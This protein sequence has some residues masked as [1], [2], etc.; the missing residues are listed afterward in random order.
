M[1]YASEYT[2][3]Y[4]SLIKVYWEAQIDL[5]A[6]TNKVDMKTQLNVF[7]DNISTAETNY[8]TRQ[9][10]LS[11]NRLR[12]R[13]QGQFSF[14]SL[15]VL[16]QHCMLF[17]AA[18]NLPAIQG[19]IIPIISGGALITD[20]DLRGFSTGWR[21]TWP[22]NGT[23][24]TPWFTLSDIGGGLGRTDE[25][26]N[27][28]GVGEA[29]ALKNAFNNNY[30]TYTA[31]YSNTT[32]YSIGIDAGAGAYGSVSDNAPLCIDENRFFQGGDERYGT[33]DRMREFLNFSNWTT[34]NF[35]R[36]RDGRTILNYLTASGP[37]TIINKPKD[38]MLAH[39]G[40]E[41]MD[42]FGWTDIAGNILP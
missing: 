25:V 30:P 41:L 6:F 32:S 40:Q 4:K 24:L 9:N 10:D 29:T 20:D 2:S 13:W 16:Y 21:Y 11:Q 17:P 42:Y 23:S 37:I 33:V 14:L 12:V 27:G 7:L 31:R 8:K 19:M 34:Q 18:A 36:F 22:G 1:P 28:I 38:W 5:T 39:G 3:T 15:Y 35:K 26:D